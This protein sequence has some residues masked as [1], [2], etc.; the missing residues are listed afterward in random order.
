MASKIFKLLL[1]FAVSS[2]INGKDYYSFVSRGD[3]DNGIYSF[4]VELEKAGAKYDTYVVARVVSSMFADSI[5]PMN[6]YLS[7]PKGAVFVERVDFPLFEATEDVSVSGDRGRGAVD[8]K[9]P[10]RAGVTV[11]D[12][13]VGMW[14]IKVEPSEEG[15][16]G[17]VLGLGFSFQER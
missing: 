12:E 9:W 15:Q 6:I 13:M 5:L 14:K 1:L 10:Y 3:S 7:S 4:N 17:K 11:N 2:C 16:A 8:F